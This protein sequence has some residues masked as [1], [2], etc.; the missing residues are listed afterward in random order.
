MTKTTIAKV[1]IIS[2]MI[3]AKE[4]LSAQ[5]NGVNPIWTN[6]D[7]GI[8]LTNPERQLHLKMNACTPFGEAGFFDRVNNPI[9]ISRESGDISL[10]RDPRTGLAL[11]RVTNCKTVNWDYKVNTNIYSQTFN[12]N[13]SDANGQIFNVDMIEFGK[14]K[15]ISFIDFEFNENAVFKKNINVLGSIIAN[16]IQA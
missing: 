7:V 9:R 2:T 14:D 4:K 5:W 15:N 16:Y 6:S 13:A 11:P 10:I 1:L 3:F 12:V 8:G